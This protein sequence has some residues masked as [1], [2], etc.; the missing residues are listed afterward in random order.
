M[1]KPLL[2]LILAV[3]LA[4]GCVT[5]AINRNFSAVQTDVGGRTGYGVAWIDVTD[6]QPE[7][8][9]AVSDL[10]AQPLTADSA[11]QIAL[12][13]NREL[14]ASF[15][16]IGIEIGEYV[17][18]GLLPNPVAEAAFRLR[19]GKT[20]IESN[21]TMDFLEAL[22]IPLRRRLQGAQ[23]AAARN[24]VTGE[25]IDL[26]AETRTSFMRYLAARQKLA[27][28]TDLLDARSAAHDMAAQLRAAGNIPLL[29]YERQRADYERAKLDVAQSELHAV[30][31][32]EELNSR[33]GL[34]GAG[35]EWAT[36]ARIPDVS[37][38]EIGLDDIEA[39]AIEASLDLNIAWYE[40]AAAAGRLGIRRLTALLPQFKAGVDA[41]RDLE[42]HLE[43]VKRE[44][45]DETEYEIEEKGTKKVWWVGPTVTW[46]IPLFDQNQGRRAAAR[47]EV[48]RR[49]ELFSA[50][51]IEV[52]NAARLAAYRLDFS[53]KRAAFL[54]QVVVP[55]QH[56][57]TLQSHLEYNA[58][59][60]GVFTLLQ[61]KERELETSR[62]YIEALLDYW[63]ARTQ[64]EQLL[65]GR[66]YD[67]QRDVFN[68][69]MK[70]GPMR[71]DEQM[72]R[73]RQDGGR[74]AGDRKGGRR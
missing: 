44:L 7:V 50:L 52:R 42:K 28:D 14:Q 8:A 41:E 24:R 47:M 64:T 36:D 17:Q 34:W 57:I 51:A 55:V 3:L 32:R 9:Q 43:I 30:E 59:A 19:G 10:L 60:Q 11:V 1:G 66:L 25:V 23:L 58:M 61:E 71:R 6:P 33:M 35:T 21:A 5:R 22:L 38:T 4:P 69:R 65:M 67:R 13:N 39:R 72:A 73:N 27:L 2:A 53:R 12:L 48:R 63:E 74:A 31:A 70:D 40:A 18:A 29:V 68:E 37:E 54:E 56:Q 46:E 49:L 15:A 16:E 26:A 62:Q 45:G 20:T